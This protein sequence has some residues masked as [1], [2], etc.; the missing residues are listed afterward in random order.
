M[1]L[2]L[3]AFLFLF[4]ATAASHAADLT[5][6]LR[7]RDIDRVQLELS[8]KKKPKLVVYL[9]WGKLVEAQILA[10]KHPGE[11]LK[12]TKNGQAVIT[13]RITDTLVYRGKVWLTF[14]DIDSAVKVMKALVSAK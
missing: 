9:G 12:I 10:G 14:P 8:P 7:D 6:D 3:F 2:A 13:P 1:R 5:L 11:P 4:F